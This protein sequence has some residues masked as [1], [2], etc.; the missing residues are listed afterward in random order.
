MTLALLIG[1]MA[2]AHVDTPE[3]I[4]RQHAIDS[5]MSSDDVVIESYP[6]RV[7]EDFNRYAI[8]WERV[9]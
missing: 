3:L 4:E 5:T 1:L 7:L 6:V 8:G 2:A 9:R